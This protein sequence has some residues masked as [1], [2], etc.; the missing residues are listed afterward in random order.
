MAEHKY[1]QVRD[2]LL[3]RVSGLPVGGQLP[4]E[5]ALCEEY[6]VSRIT[7]RRAVEELVNDGHLI[8]EHGRGTFVTR[9][10]Y[11]LKHRERFVSEV[12][13]FFTQM[14]RQGHEVTSEVLV[15]KRARAGARLAA[16]L[17]ISPAA[18]V[19]RL[20]RLRRVNGVVHHLAES[21]VE[22]ERFA[23]VLTADFTTTSLYAHLR[24][25]HDV[26]LARNEI[27]VGLHTCDR[28]EAELLG[29]EEG[30]PL[31]LATSRVFDLNRKPVIHG[32]SKF[33]PET[34]ELSFDIIADAE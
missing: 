15:Q 9:P 17:D 6:A 10:R 13:G 26:L 1:A 20:E 2:H 16:A 5:A 21:Y 23:D 30:S 4:P 22:E 32:T 8:R 27:V 14:S 12:T 18:S 7:L 34:A 24:A 29:V 19:V 3:R 31:L 33:L 11:A 25:H 28:R